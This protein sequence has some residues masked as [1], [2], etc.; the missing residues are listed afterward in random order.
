V[1]KAN[2]RSNIKSKLTDVDP[3]PADDWTD[4]VMG[5]YSLYRLGQRAGADDMKAK[6]LEALENGASKEQLLAL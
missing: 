2:I 4:A 6:M 1:F 5:L 3:T